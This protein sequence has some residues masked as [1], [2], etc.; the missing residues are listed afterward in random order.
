MVSIGVKSACFPR[1]QRMLRTQH[2]EKGLRPL[3]AEVRNHSIGL[4]PSRFAGGPGD[5]P[6]CPCLDSQAREQESHQPFGHVKNIP[7]TSPLGNTAICFHHWI[8]QWNFN[9]LT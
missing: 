4:H 2:R 9:L 5:A 3:L 8:P 7:S 6:L 1:E